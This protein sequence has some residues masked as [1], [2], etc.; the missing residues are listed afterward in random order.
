MPPT[1]T[2][3]FEEIDD[4]LAYRGG[5]L[6][7]VNEVA[8]G[9]LVP[10]SESFASV[11]NTGGEFGSQFSATSI[12]NPDSVYGG[13]F[14]EQSP[15]NPESTSPPSIVVDGA[16]VASLSVSPLAVNA[17]DPAAVLTELGCPELLP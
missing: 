12:F 10:A 1:P 17:V 2:P 13:P 6:V 7:G 4:F 15:F 11:C 16:V 5:Q 8:L 3:E 14:G 9:D